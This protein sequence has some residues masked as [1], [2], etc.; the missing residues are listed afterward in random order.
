MCNVSVVNGAGGSSGTTNPSNASSTEI[1]SSNSSGLQLQLPI[2]NP[3]PS[4][5]VPP[6]PI[7]L[8]QPTIQVK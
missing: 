5:A 2:Y 7:H 6:P 8:S 4:L 1:I 3:P